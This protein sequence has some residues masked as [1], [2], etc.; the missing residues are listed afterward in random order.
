LGD[1]WWSGWLPFDWRFSDVFFEADL[2]VERRCFELGCGPQFVL[3]RLHADFILAQRGRS[4]A[5]LGV[6]AHQQAMGWLIQQIQRQPAPGVVDRRLPFAAIF[7]MMSQFLQRIGGPFF[8]ILAE[9]ELPLVKVRAVVQ[10]KPVQKTA[11]VKGYG[12]GEV[13]QTGRA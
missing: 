9:E 1:T 13:L 3:E 2:L 6:Q 12:G 8:E 10:R 4:L 5:A 11:V 7:M